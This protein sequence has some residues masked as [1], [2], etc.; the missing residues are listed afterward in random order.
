MLEVIFHGQKHFPCTSQTS[1]TINVDI[2]FVEHTTK[3]QV[4]YV[5]TICSH[6][7]QETDS[8]RIYIAMKVLC[9]IIMEEEIVKN[10]TLIAGNVS[11]SSEFTPLS[12]ASMRS[13]LIQK[14]LDLLKVNYIDESFSV[15]ILPL[16]GVELQLSVT[17]EDLIPYE[18]VEK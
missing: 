7:D 8:I 14:L 3:R 18:I 9:D 13:V 15:E 11:S 10:Q 4:Q 12:S 5:E 17:P 2:T 1:G 6:I 16:N